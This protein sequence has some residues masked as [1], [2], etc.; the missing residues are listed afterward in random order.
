[1]AA[2]ALDP[3]LLAR[4]PDAARRLARLARDAGLLTR[5]LRDGVALAPP[6]IINAEQVD[7][8]ATSLTTALEAL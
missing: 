8:A 5:G 3:E 4:E 7:I 6:L 1:M 2:V